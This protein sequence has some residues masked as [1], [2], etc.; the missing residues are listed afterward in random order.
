MRPPL[1][2]P[3]WKAPTPRRPGPDCGAFRIIEPGLLATVQD[4]GRPGHAAE[5][6]AVSG[7][8]DRGALRTANRLV[9]NGESAAGIEVTLG[10]FRAVAEVDLAIVVTGAWGPVRLDG[11]LIDPYSVHSWAAGAE[12]S[13]DWFDHGARAYL[14]VRGGIEAPRAL[15][16]RSTDTL[17]GLGRA[18]L[19]A[20][21]RVAVGGAASGPIPTAE[22]MP[23]GAPNDDVI[24]LELAPGP[25]ADWFTPASVRALF[26]GEWVVSNRADRVGIRLDGPPLERVRT[27]E[28]P[29]E[30]MIPGALQV[31][32]DG[33]P[34]ILGADGPVTGGYPVIAVV[35]D[36]SLDALAQ[37]RPGTRI[38]FRHARA[39]HF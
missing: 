27:G 17:A 31:P 9:G 33:L 18:P 5:G 35:S 6:V 26:D 4:Q 13:I 30:G 20:G 3:A 2:R 37:A 14:A 28:L 32:P 39:T 25:R 34:V 12:L 10:G 11:H 15:G 16:S 36:A 38:R 29:S 22:V 24:E 23:W 1:R 7:A 21:D 8:L 19:A